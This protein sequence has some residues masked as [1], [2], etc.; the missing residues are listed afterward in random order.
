MNLLSLIGLGVVVFASTNIDDIFVLMM[1][2]SDRS[3]S[4]SQVV[5][6]Q[7]LGI[8]L[9]MGISALG[10][11]AALVV[12]TGVV[13]LMGFL[14]IAI[15]VKKLLDTRTPIEEGKQNQEARG[16]LDTTGHLRFLTIT[17]VTF[18]NGGDNIAIYIPLFANSTLSEI[19]VLFVIFAVMVAVWCATAYY[20]VNHSFV[21]DYIRRL[22]HVLLPFVLIG[23]GVYILAEAFLFLG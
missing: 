18:S 7:Y 16:A 15:G 10:M 6:G 21:G 23:L 9:L 22:G 14:P 13:G 12:P 20:L 17:A 4:T 19:G 5:V 8:A 3:F 1:F 2:F 11:V